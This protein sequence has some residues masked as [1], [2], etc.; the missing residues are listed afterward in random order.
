[1]TTRV[2]ERAWLGGTLRTT[3]RGIASNALALGVLGASSI[4]LPLSQLLPIGG[5]GCTLRTSPDAVGL[6]PVWNGAAL[7]QWAVPNAP[8]L[9]G[10][11]F[12][13]QTLVLESTAGTA[14]ALTASQA[15]QLTIGA[16]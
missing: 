8:A 5:A 14:T 3:T 13:Q 16:F 12:V 7:G 1:M 4:S 6:L 2:D 15:L 11:T 10:G 9:L